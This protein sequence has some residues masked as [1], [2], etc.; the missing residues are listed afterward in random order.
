MDEFAALPY[1][2]KTLYYQQASA[3]GKINNPLIIE[4][5]FWVTF[6]LKQLFTD[7]NFA[8]WFTFKGGTSLSKIYR[9]IDRFSEDVDISIDRKALGFGGDND[10]AHAPSFTKVKEKLEALTAASIEAIEKQILP[11]LREGCEKALGSNNNWD[12]M[13]DPN[14]SQTILFSFPT[15]SAKWAGSYFKPD[16]KIE[17]GAKNETWPTKRVQIESYLSETLPDAIDSKSVEVEVLRAERTFW[18]KATILHAFYHG[19]HSKLRPNQSRH[20]YDLCKLAQSPICDDALANID[21]LEKVAIHKATFFRQGWAKYKL[22]RVG[23]LRLTP[24]DQ[25]SIDL[26]AQDYSQMQ[27]MFFSNTPTFKEILDQLGQLQSKVNSLN[28]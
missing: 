27:S 3:I 28:I 1:R 18:E 5:D 26:L 24:D 10:P 14:E 9:L 22:A 15:D 4:K 2:E 23:T 19:G 21:L 6:I 12:L 20:Y 13:I 8:N 11:S 25:K 7:R 17:F 16:V